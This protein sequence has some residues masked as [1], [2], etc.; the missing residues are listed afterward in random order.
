MRSAC[1]LI[2]FQGSSFF[3]LVARN[4]L[5][6]GV[7][8]VPVLMLF[9]NQK[10][11]GRSRDKIIWGVARPLAVPFQSNVQAVFKLTDCVLGGSTAHGDVTEVDWKETRLERVSERV[12]AIRAEMIVSCE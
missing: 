12:E 10:R 8:N 5:H 3:W 6:R 2:R 1:A 7:V 11:V 4:R 9:R